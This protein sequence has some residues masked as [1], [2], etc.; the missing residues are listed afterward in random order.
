MSHVQASADMYL[1][2]RLLDLV[3]RVQSPQKSDVLL[4][5][6]REHVRA[7]ASLASL[8]ADT[9][10]RY[11]AHLFSPFINVGRKW[12]EDPDTAAV[13]TLLDALHLK[14]A[15]EDN[16][17]AS[18][19]RKQALN[20]IERSVFN[21]A[22][23][24]TRLVLLHAL[25]HDAVNAELARTAAEY[26]AAIAR[27][28]VD[29]D[30]AR[31]YVAE[32]AASFAASGGREKRARTSTST[33]R[34]ERVPELVLVLENV[35]FARFTGCKPLVAALFELLAALN[36]AHGAS[37]IQYAGQLVLASMSK[38]TQQHEASFADVVKVGVILDLMRAVASPQI[39]N[40]ALL[41][42]SKFAPL[43]PD[44]LSH[45]ILPIFTF[46]GANIQR[47]DAYSL[48]VVERT[49]EN[50]VPALVKSAR[51]RASSRTELTANM[52]DLL[53]TFT[54][55]ASHVPKH[56][57]VKLFSH[58]V[59]ALGVNDFLAP[60]TLLLLERRPAVSKKTVADGAL[61]AQAVFESNTVDKQLHAIRQL[62]DEALAI[63]AFVGA[64]DSG[65][66][67]DA[68][69]VDVLADSDA[70][71]AQA[72]TVVRFVGDMLASRQFASKMDAVRGDAESARVGSALQLVLRQL[73]ELSSA[74]DKLA[75]VSRS[76]LETAV[77]LLSAPMLAETVSWL[78]DLPEPVHHGVGKRI[79]RD[80]LPALK[81][82]RRA[83]VSPAVVT[84]LA[85][86]ER[87][88]SDE[89]AADDDD[90][91]VLNLE[92]VKVIASG[93]SND[94]EASALGKVLPSILGY[95]ERVALA[96]RAPCLAVLGSLVARLGPRAIPH[97]ARLV[98]LATGSAVETKAQPAVVAAA[99]QLMHELTSTLPSFLGATHVSTI[100][101]TS[102][103]T[104]VLEC[105]SV[106][107][108]ARRAR[109][110]VLNA[111]ARK[112]AFKTILGAITDLHGSLGTS[113]PQAQYIALL[114]VLQRVLR[115]AHAHDVTSSTRQVFKLFL[116][117]LDLRSSP[118]SSEHY[119]VATIEHHAL[120]AFMQLVLKLNEQT[121]RPMFARVF[122]WAVVDCQG[123]VA[124]ARQT[125]LYKLFARLVSQLQVRR[126]HV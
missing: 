66:H 10:E 25:A 101:R 21:A 20:V 3:D 85:Q 67:T 104:H 14:G 61:L 35:D 88:F 100:L 7:P 59:G 49:L 54:N 124:V 111:L 116:A 118:S 57:R 72:L 105:A 106:S 83:L 70:A 121:F 86:L 120:G 109:T 56:R 119:D 46:M 80:R 37:D 77:A 24:E 53:R 81:P 95:S 42:L 9:L 108:A 73:I 114:D 1:R 41:L 84:A 19:L 112:V 74:S 91:V 125:V 107:A 78:L 28:A 17:V 45:H 122:D 68:F 26:V 30:T 2:V 99:L 8:D 117:V 31:L 51:A 96:A 62:L 38:A 22:R 64:G 5:L 82:A 110:G 79:L 15:E 39:A 58:F 60:V 97:V 43:V 123:P 63:A 12:L 4:P 103:D 89:T 6:L 87:E 48:R 126:P 27:C 113:S 76:A 55:A 29:A 33:P 40:Q 65:A 115:N 32:V 16:A 47:D 50:I 36:D 102:I 93:E 75:G 44:Q 23:S 94:D 69:L 18:A 13:P 90:V 92:V 98:K 71:V 52:R 34:T 11:V